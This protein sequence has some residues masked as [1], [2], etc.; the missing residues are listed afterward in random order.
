MIAR[1]VP[2]RDAEL[3]YVQGWRIMTMDGSSHARW[4]VL[5]ILDDGWDK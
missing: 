4:S 5:A 3:Y 1:Y 2:W